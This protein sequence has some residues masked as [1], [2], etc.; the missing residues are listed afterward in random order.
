MSRYK[1]Q[2]TGGT[3]DVN[4]QWYRGKVTTTTADVAITAGFISPIAK[5]IFAK[6]GMA[7]VMEILR[8][9]FTI[10][11]YPP[12]A[13]VLETSEGRFC[14]LTTRDHGID[15]VFADEPDI[16]AH[17]RDGSIGAFTA[18]GTYQMFDPVTICMD[19]TDGA[20]HGILV[21]SDY[22]YFQGDTVAFGVTTT[23]RFAIL[24]RFKNVTLTEYIGIV[25]SQQ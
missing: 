23:W 5:G 12:V 14:C 8:V 22:I 20:G 16:I 2:L 17:Y 10:P 6:K 24:Y 4:P 18:G 25:Q 7:T 9:V 13:A 11:A 3:G 15:V 1:T 19:L 21:G